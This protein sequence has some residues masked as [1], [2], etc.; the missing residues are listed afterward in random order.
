MGALRARVTYLAADQLHPYFPDPVLAN[1]PNQPGVCLLHLWTL[2][3]A[4]VPVQPPKITLQK[5]SPGFQSIITVKLEHACPSVDRSAGAA[6]ASSKIELS[7]LLQLLTSSC[8]SQPAL[9]LLSSHHAIS[10]R[11]LPLTWTGARWDITQSTTLVSQRCLHGSALVPQSPGGSWIPVLCPFSPS[12]F[13]IGHQVSLTSDG[14]LEA[15]SKAM[16]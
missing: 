1:S 7:W 13:W 5:D 14:P 8:I 11:L 6:A 16:A 4:T 3:V 12:Q 10:P 9:P 2:T 15:P